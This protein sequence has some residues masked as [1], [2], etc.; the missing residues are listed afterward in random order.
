ML[1]ILVYKDEPIA[2]GAPGNDG[3]APRLTDPSALDKKPEHW[4]RFAKDKWRWRTQDPLRS[5]HLKEIVRLAY[6]ILTRKIAGRSI[7]VDN[8][9]S[10]QLQLGYILK[11]LGDLYEFSERD[12]FSVELET[13][14]PL[15]EVSAKA[16]SKRARADIILALGT[17]QVFAMC[18]IELKFFKQKNHREPK[19]YFGHLLSERG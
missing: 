1:T 13:Y 8:E 5:D 7:T 18:A 2:L 3:M 4:L 6:G 14:I 15:N 12:L 10:F 17:E 9:A 16:G 11:I 19:Q